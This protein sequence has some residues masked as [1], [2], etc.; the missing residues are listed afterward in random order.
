MSFFNLMQQK[1]Q[2][3]VKEN[4]WQDEVVR[5][6]VKT[7]TPQEAIGNP[8]DRDYPLIKGRERMMEADFLGSRGQAFTDMYGSFAGTLEQ[9]VTMKL[10][11][12][13]KRAIF[14]AALNA[15]ARHLGI[16]AKTI[17]CK[18]DRPPQCAKELMSYIREN[19]GQPRV[20]LVGFQ[21]RMAQAL[22]QEFE[23]RVTDM[24][25]DNAGTVKFGISIQGPERTTGNIAWCDV[26]VVTGSTLTNDTLRDLLTEKRTI[27]YGVTIAASAHLLNLTRFCPY[28]T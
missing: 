13:F 21:P 14:L 6:D 7:L 12:N 8:E 20:A 16:V 3:L 23:L 26:A 10:E 15:V 22:A 25:P 28:G 19:Y 9:V 27:F 24:D 18:D 1:F 2:H 11:N 4:S 5:V 17:H